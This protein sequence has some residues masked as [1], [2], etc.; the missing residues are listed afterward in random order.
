MDMDTLEVTLPSQSGPQ[1][2]TSVPP[3]PPNPEKDALLS[4]LSSTLVASTRRTVEQNLA[5]VSPLQAQQAALQT[6]RAKLTAELEQMGQLEKALERNEGI[7]R[8][9]RFPFLSPS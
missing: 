8:E 3:V 4:A 5:A 1:H 2:P 9:V 7:L 6:A